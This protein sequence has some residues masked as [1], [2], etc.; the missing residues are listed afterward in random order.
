MRSVSR[1][2]CQTWLRSVSVYHDLTSKAYEAG[3][4]TNERS[5]DEF[6]KG[7]THRIIDRPGAVVRLCEELAAAGVSLAKSGVSGK[8]GYG[9]ATLAFLLMMR[10]AVNPVIIIFGCGMLQWAIARGL[11]GLP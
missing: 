7:E 9:I 10:A 3:Y 6:W 8:L 1:V 5:P 11:I 4:L 2:S